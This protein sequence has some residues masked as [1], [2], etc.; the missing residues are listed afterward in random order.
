M[1]CINSE[2]VCGSLELHQLLFLYVEKESD[3]FNEIS[4]NKTVTHDEPTETYRTT[5]N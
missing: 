2:Q 1:Q 3:T 4:F 5:V